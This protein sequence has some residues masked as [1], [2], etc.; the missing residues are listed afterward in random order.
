MK[1]VII[2]GVS[3]DIGRNICELFHRDGFNISRYCVILI[4]LSDEKNYNDGGGELVIE[5]NG[6]REVIKPVKGN[7]CILDFT[8]NNPNH[9][10]NVVK[11]YCW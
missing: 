7:F 5:E 10:V 11:R 9:A 2:L 1:N 4:Y 6:V 3:A 8:R